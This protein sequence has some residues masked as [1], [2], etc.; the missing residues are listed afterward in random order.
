MEKRSGVPHV[1][2]WHVGIS[3][4]KIVCVGQSADHCRRVASIIGV[5]GIEIRRATTPV[6]K[7]AVRGRDGAG[8]FKIRPDG[9]VTAT[10]RGYDNAAG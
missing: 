9:S 7:G 1:P 2:T 6:V 10:K 3:G 8:S 4:G 5:S